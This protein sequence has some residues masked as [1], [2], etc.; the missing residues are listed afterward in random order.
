V[1]QFL[2]VRA[3]AGVE[4]V[5]QRGYARTV[6]CNG[7]AGRILLT[8]L[9]TED[10]LELRMEGIATALVP[11]VCASAG[12]MFDLAAEPARILAGLSA[13]PLLGP[14]V[15]CRP[16]LRIPGAWDAF[17]CAVRA[18]LGQ[19]VSV[20]AGR[21][22]AQRLV[23]RAGIV[24]PGGADGLTHLF[25][26]PAGL[27]AAELGGI[28]ITGARARTLHALARAVVDGRVDFAAP[29]AQLAAALTALSGIGAWTAQYVLLR[30][31]GEPDAFPGAD[32]VLRRMAGSAGRLLDGAELEA[33]AR[34]WQPWRGYAVMH[35][36]GAAAAAA[37]AP[38][39]GSRR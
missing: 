16:G 5:D 22:F 12:R 30:A 24:L 2:A 32:L 21:T 17:E 26:T 27:A 29:P 28:G 9:P 10:A 19:Q 33:R 13:D 25:P 3:V 1:L 8:Q 6:A 18:V 7:T 4:R 36:W 39:M 38:T 31:Q 11:Q 15:N 37:P 14:L 35:L 34:G 23:A 20:A